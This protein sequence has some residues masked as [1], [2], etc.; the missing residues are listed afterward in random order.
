[1]SNGIGR[2]GTA[3]GMSVSVVF[4]NLSYVTGLPVTLSV[5]SVRRGA[6]L[7][8]RRSIRVNGPAHFVFGDYRRFPEFTWSVNA[9]SPADVVFLQFTVQAPRCHG[10][11]R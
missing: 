2:S 9:D 1:M 11:D 8:P 10:S 4:K 3:G 6:L 7:L 5:D